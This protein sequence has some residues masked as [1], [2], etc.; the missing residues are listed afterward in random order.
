MEPPSIFLAK[1]FDSRKVGGSCSEIF[2][3]DVKSERIVA[4]INHGLVQRGARL[5]TTYKSGILLL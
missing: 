5:R 3:R 2:L 1:S 4:F